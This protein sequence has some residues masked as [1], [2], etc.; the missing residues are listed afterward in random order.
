ML[1]LKRM[2]NAKVSVWIISSRFLL[3]TFVKLM[4][5][6]RYLF[7]HPYLKTYFGMKN[8]ANNLKKYSNKL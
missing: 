5:E 1:N 8:N 2:P 3:N 6:M 4:Y 7:I